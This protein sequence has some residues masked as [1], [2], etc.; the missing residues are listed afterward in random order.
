MSS[1][2]EKT[3]GLEEYQETDLYK[4]IEGLTDFKNLEAKTELTH[5]QVIVVSRAIW[6][7]NKYNLPTLSK[8]VEQYLRHLISK[9]RK[10]RLELVTAI[11]SALETEKEKSKFREIKI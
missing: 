5:N 10:G 4:T 8:F 6:F 11:T 3:L 7:A 2:V 9:D 1:D